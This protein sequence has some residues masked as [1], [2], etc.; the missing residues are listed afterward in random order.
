I[1]DYYGRSLFHC[2]YCDGWELRDKPLV[3]IIGEQVQ[4]FHFIQTIYNWSKDLIVCTNNGEAFRNSAQ[5]SLL[6]N[7]GIKIIESKIKNFVGKNGQIEK[8][9]F[10]NG[11][12]V[13]RKGGFVMPQLIQASDFGKQLGCQYTPLGYIAIDSFGRTNIQGVYAAGDASVI[14]PA[15]LIIAAAEGVRAAAGVN[16]DLTQKEFLELAI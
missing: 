5:K 2:P 9:I 10:E 3:V 14:A 8:I 15:Q 12:S 4:G 7:K 6:Q 16:N 11:E 13:L 1:S